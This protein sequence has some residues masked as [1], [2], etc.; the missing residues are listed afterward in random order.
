MRVTITL[1]V[2][3]LAWTTAAQVTPAVHRA[4]QENPVMKAAQ[5]V[6]VS[7]NSGQ[8]APTIQSGKDKVSYAFGVDLA[9]DLK[10][11]KEDLNVDLLI[12]ALTDALA[13]KNLL[14]TDEEV[15][16]TLKTVEAEQKH[17]LEHAKAMIAEKN[18]KAIEAFV[19]ENVK[20]EG[21]VTLPSGLQ[22]KI[23]KQ[24]DGKVPLLDDHVVCHYR[25]TLIDG[26]EFDSSYQRNQPAT[27]PVK[28]VMAGWAQALQLMPVGSKWQIFIPPQ[29]AYGERV[30]S[31]IGPNAMLIFEVDLVSI[32]DKEQTPVAHRRP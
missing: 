12:R 23:L 1:G 17:D 21:V 13:D 2:A 15:T 28:G 24:G 20:K 8:D 11:Q 5:E 26:T 27:L 7:G 30:V 14:M 6:T 10:R 9:R 3:I 16:A 18:R 22:Y 4:Q 29:L 31:G 32:Q 19:A 25:G